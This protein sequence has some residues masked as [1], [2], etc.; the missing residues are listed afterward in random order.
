MREAD[1]GTETQ[2][3]TKNLSVK[4]LSLCNFRNYSELS[5]I[6][7]GESLIITG[8]NGA[9][10]TN[11]L[12]AVSM[13]VPGRGIRN[14]KLSD[15]DRK[16]STINYEPSTIFSSSPWSVYAEIETSDDVVA[17]GTG[18][19]PD[20]RREKRIVKIN[21]EKQKSQAAM[22]EYFAVCTLTPKS[23]QILSEGASSRRNWL[24]KIAMG[25]YPEHARHLAIYSHAKSERGRIISR[26]NYDSEWADVLERRMAEQAVAIADARVET[27]EHLQKAI[28]I[29]ESHFPKP[30][31]SVSGL[32]EEAVTKMPALHAEEMLKEKLKHTRE[33][34]RISGRTSFGVHKSD[35]LVLHTGKNMPAEQCSTGEQKALV[36]AITL[37]TAKARKDWRGAAPVMLLDEIASHLDEWKRAEFFSELDDISTQ[38]WMT[39]TDISFF[40]DFRGKK[41]FLTV[42]NSKIL[43]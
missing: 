9:G 19:D 1:S 31:L 17:I 18:R 37:A 13:L 30:E 40:K 43:G 28:N 23:D 39:G 5:F 16:P 27:I 12:E 3:K 10:K 41:R 7:S 4:K 38:S 2:T 24:D 29:R 42:E 11:L 21:T 20:S 8:N 35:F 22:S 15:I 32:V 6:S 25:F 14:A 36:L 33:T 26:N 34:D